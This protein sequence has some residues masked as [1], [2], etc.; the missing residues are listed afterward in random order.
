MRRVLVALVVSLVLAAAAGYVFWV[1]PTRQAV[2]IGS[3]M[4]AKQMC[5]CMFVAERSE[6]ECRADQFDSM[7][8]IRV[9]ILTEPSGVRAFVP[10]LGERS[11]T[12]RRGLGCTLR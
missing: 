10:W 7:D 3:G 6:P 8:P 2:A 5:S 1:V 9:E 4:L 11:A 12:W